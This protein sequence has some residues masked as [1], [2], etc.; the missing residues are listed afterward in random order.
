MMRLALRTLRFRKSGFVATFVAV[1]FGAAIV[2]A[3]GGLMET[4]IRTNVP[5]V[6]LAAAPIIV[7]GDQTHELPNSEES[8][9]LPE[10]VRLPADLVATV[11]SVPGVVEA[12]G[13]VSFPVTVLPAGG[14]AEGHGWGS[15]VLAP[16]DLRAGTAPHAGEVVLDTTTADRAGVRVGQRVEIA[17]RGRTE[18]FRVSGVADGPVTG[19]LFSAVDTTRLAGRPGTVDAIGV[20]VAPG[21]NLDELRDRIDGVLDGKAVIL[22]GADRG[23]AEHPE[24]A[25]R[26]NL[27]ALAG[28]FG[29]IATMTMMFVI[30]ATLTLSVQQRLR[31]LALMRTVGGTPARIR[32]MVIGETVMVSL[33]AVL[34]G[35]LPGLFLGEWLFDRLAE[36]G[37][38]SPYVDYQQGLLPLAIG[39]G[40]AVLASLGAAVIAGRQA[41]RVRPIEALAEAGLQRRWF[42]WARFVCG[43][44]FLGGGAALVIVTVAVMHGPLASATAGPSVLGWAIGAALLGPAITTAV[45]KLLRWPVRALSGVNGRLAVL[46]VTAR[47]VAI[48]AAVTPVMLAVGIATANLYMQTTQVAAAEDAYAEDLRADAV[49]SS[50]TGGLAPDLLDKVRNTPGV[51]GAS[52]YITSTGVIEDSRASQDSAG[53]L[54]Q[55]VSAQGPD[56][57]AAPRLTSG[58]LTG[59]SG[60]TVALPERQARKLRRAVGDE[61]TMTL[62]DGRQ[63][64]VR[65]VA[66]FAAREGYEYILMPADLVAAHTAAGVPSQI[67][68]RLDPG[69]DPAVLSGPGLSV[70][71]REAL[72]ARHSDGEQTQAWVNYM[73]VGLIVAYTAVSVINTLSA[74]TVRRRREF[75]LQR[76][77]GSTRGQV[78]RM[79]FVEGLLVAAAGIV[80]GTAVA[81]L[82]LVPYSATVAGSAWP[83]GPVWIY[84]AVV[85]SAVLLTLGAT[86]VPAWMSLRSRPAEAAV[87]VD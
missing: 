19:G 26:E 43:L 6:R 24:A 35:C 82:T 31:E 33:P 27:V 10:R 75:G 86:T 61:I 30:A 51:A 20:L 84:L 73:L 77:S 5:A 69:T 68:A 59:L 62:G 18:T 37:V 58:S 40:A 14:P 71:G 42:G 25:G 80:I 1:M 60:N 55:G 50:T 63:E 53:W 7:V 47:T 48:S 22:A 56:G 36:N 67:M 17:V 52:A 11:R 49:V 3:C 64:K 46:N 29:G 44:L 65:I 45:M 13:D 15:A 54:L 87:A 72:L 85:A 8:A 39:A 32:R 66:T 4:G 74:S 12:V 21:T 57:P 28:S 16:Y 76:L 9:L 83:S 2:M 23:I 38:V 78:L 34:L 81:L 70:L 79:T 41:G